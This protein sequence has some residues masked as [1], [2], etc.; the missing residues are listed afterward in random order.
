[1]SGSVF[2]INKYSDLSFVLEP[3]AERIEYTSVA[4]GL[5]ATFGSDQ[6]YYFILAEFAKLGRTYLRKIRERIL[7][8]L[9][10]ARKDEFQFPYRITAP[11]TGCGF[12][13]IPM[14]KDMIAHRSNGHQ[15]LAYA[16]KYEQKL[17]RQVSAS[18]AFDGEDYLIEWM[19]LDAS[20]QYN[21]EME[22]RLKESYP[23][24]PLKAQDIKRYNL[25]KK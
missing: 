21:A 1:M 5:P 4:E 14:T 16:S 7:L 9:E 23:F 3:F 10:M 18:F 2:S 11:S 22:K 25:E 24:R 20:W 6:H 12:L 17:G 13:F 8:S 15:N 19:Y